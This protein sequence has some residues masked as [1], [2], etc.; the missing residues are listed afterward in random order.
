[1]WDTSEELY[2]PLRFSLRPQR[3]FMNICVWPVVLAHGPLQGGVVQSQSPEG[4][5]KHCCTLV[6]SWCEGCTVEQ[7]QGEQVVP[8]PAGCGTE[9][10]LSLPGAGRKGPV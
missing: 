7:P 8:R 4:R 10:D 3:A 9:G 1:M 5:G 6:G 2:E